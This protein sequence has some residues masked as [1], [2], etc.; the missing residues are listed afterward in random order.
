M[1]VERCGAELVM[2]DTEG[3]RIY[4]DIVPLRFEEWRYGM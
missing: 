1:A 2:E 3:L 4:D